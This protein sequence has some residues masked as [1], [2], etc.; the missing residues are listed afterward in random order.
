MI[1]I[2]HIAVLNK[3]ALANGRNWRA[4]VQAAWHRACES[5]PTLTVSERAK[6]Q[7][8]RNEGGPE[9]LKNFKPHPEGYKAI[10]YLQK[11]K[12]EKFNLKRGWFVTAWRLVS[13]PNVD[14]VQPWS[15]TKSEARELA[16]ALQI[17]LLPSA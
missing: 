4:E 11:D 13:A 9:F 7:Q 16:H 5:M 6:L 17:C 15:D 12:Q 2:E 1:T 8:L 14:L 10:G 3:V